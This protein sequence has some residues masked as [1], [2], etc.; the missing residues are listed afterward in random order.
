MG[1]SPKHSSEVPLILNTAT[2]H[3]LPQFYV[4]FDDDFSTVASIGED[5][6]PLS[7]WNEFDIDDFMYKVQLDDT[8]NTY[9]QD[10]WLTPQEREEAERDRV[11]L[12]Q[13]RSKVQ[14]TPTSSEL[15]LLS[16]SSHTSLS[17]LSVANPSRLLIKGEPKYVDAVEFASDLHI[18]SSPSA[19]I[20]QDLDSTLELTP[21]QSLRRSPRFTSAPETSVVSEVRRSLRLQNQ[22]TERKFQD[23]VFDSSLVDPFTSYQEQTLAYHTVLDTDFETGLYNGT[24]SRAY[25]ASHKLHNP[26]QPSLHEALHGEDS[27]HYIEAMK[28]EIAQLLKQRT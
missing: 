8:S 13:L 11:R 21:P 20:P 27:H 7:F 15:R 12:A 26:D 28:I 2:G 3:I 25:A 24:D 9:L 22:Q 18:E 19:S 10:E 6:P 16:S 4:V 5:E 14:S 1:F 23:E 17:A